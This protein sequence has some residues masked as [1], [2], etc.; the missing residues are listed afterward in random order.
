MPKELDPMNEGQVVNLAVDIPKEL[1]ADVKWR[2]SDP[3]VAIV[4]DTQD[5]RSASAMT[6]GGG[7]TQIGVEVDLD[8]GHPDYDTPDT[9]AEKVR[10]ANEVAQQFKIWFPKP[11]E[12]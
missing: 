5:G 2:S 3:D 10:R 8:L 6:V 12:H 1:A 9:V 7:V 11:D 4:I